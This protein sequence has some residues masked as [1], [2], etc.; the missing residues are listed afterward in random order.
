MSNQ[1]WKQ[2]E[3]R[4]AKFFGTVRTPLSGGNSRITRSDSLHNKL[5]IEIKSRRK[6]PF[7]K[8]FRETIKQAKQE[9]K[10][11]VFVIHEANHKDDICFMRLADTK[12]F[13]SIMSK[14]WR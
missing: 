10:L 3:R 5:F 1:A 13:V 14:Q 12:K 11:P 9:N 4:V 7:L 2:L 8:Q 6:V